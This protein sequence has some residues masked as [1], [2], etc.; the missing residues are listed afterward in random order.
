LV[1]SLG[2]AQNPGT[3]TILDQIGNTPL[4]RLVGARRKAARSPP[5]ARSA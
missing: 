4:V 2:V 5:Y 1:F 3:S